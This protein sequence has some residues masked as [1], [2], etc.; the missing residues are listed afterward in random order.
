MK[1]IFFA[2]SLIVLFLSGLTLSSCQLFTKKLKPFKILKVTDDA[3]VKF[4]EGN[5][6]DI[7]D[8]SDTSDIQFT[9]SGDTLIIYGNSDAELVLNPNK[10]ILEQVIVDKDADLNAKDVSITN[11][12]LN[13]TVV[14]NDDGDASLNLNNFQNVTIKASGDADINLTGSS[15][16]TTLNLTGQS[17]V[18][19]QNF[20]TNVCSVDMSENSDAKIAVTDTLKGTIRDYST[21]TYYGNPQVNVQVLDD[22]NLAQGK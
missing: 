13:F 2:M 19:A 14:V 5:N 17:D 20:S 21:L 4:K 9:I 22:A 8:I 3:D 10:V 6:L 12:S 11:E 15:Y 7:N 1:R 16:N 18:E